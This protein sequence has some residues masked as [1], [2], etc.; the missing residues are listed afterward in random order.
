MH[1]GIIRN[2]SMSMCSVIIDGTTYIEILKILSIREL[3]IRKLVMKSNLAVEP[4]DKQNRKRFGNCDIP[5]IL[6]HSRLLLLYF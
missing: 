1:F 2:L 5:Q 3:G 6:L 4:I